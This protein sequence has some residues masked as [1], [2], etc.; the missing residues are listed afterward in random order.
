[1][2]AAEAPPPAQKPGPDTAVANAPTEKPAGPAGTPKP[3]ARTSQ[4]PAP[5]EEK[6]SPKRAAAAAEKEPDAGARA[7]EP[8]KPRGQT[9]IPDELLA[10]T[11]Q[12]K[13]APDG[14]TRPRK[15]ESDPEAAAEAT[16]GTGVPSPDRPPSRPRPASGSEPEPSPG[17]PIPGAEITFQ[18]ARV[19][20]FLD[21]GGAALDGRVVDADT[22]KA[23]DAADIEAWMGTRS[24]EAET[25]P[26]GRFRFEGLIPGSRLMLW[27]TSAPTHVQERTEVVV[28]A[29][30][31]SFQATFRLLSRTA[32][33]GGSVD[34]GAGMFLTRR[35]SRTVV[36]G[37]AAF[38]PAEKAGVKVGDAIVAVGKRQV[39]ELGPGAID[40][41]L[42]GTIGS[43]L[44]LTVQTGSA[45]PRKLT[46]QRSAR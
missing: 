3:A 42:R 9:V 26:Q 28:P 4:D 18:S 5:P 39:G 37:L 40:F 17:L 31:T 20:R 33:P 29:N 43:D 34:G 22:G 23:V 11:A 30:Q 7:G 13:D 25:D 15:P 32:L 10:E 2:Q 46:M 1:V 44:E 6:P 24:V 41:L 35:G 27:I 21:S 45:S 36:T 16:G 19:R 12:P 38:G 8:G 14:G